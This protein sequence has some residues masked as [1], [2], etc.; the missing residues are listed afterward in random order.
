MTLHHHGVPRL[1]RALFLLA[2][3]TAFVMAL[4][5]APPQVMAND[6]SQHMLAFVVLTALMG[7]GWPRLALWRI[8]L[9]MALVGALIEIAQWAFPALHRDADIADWYADMIAVGVVLLVIAL[10]RAGLRAR[11]PKPA[12]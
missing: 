3:I 7:I 6:K 2:L 12:E 11:S 10:I 9:P 5:P 1:A 8:A 4:L